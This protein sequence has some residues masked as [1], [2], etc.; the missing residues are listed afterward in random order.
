MLTFF[1]QNTAKRAG[2]G[3][4]VAYLL[5]GSFHLSGSSIVV[6]CMLWEHEVRVRFSAPRQRKRARCAGHICGPKG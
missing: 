6:V 3:V 4:T 2:R 1:N 5:W